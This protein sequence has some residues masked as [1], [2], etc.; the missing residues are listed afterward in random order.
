[1]TAA[2]ELEKV[3]LVADFQEFGDPAR[4]DDHG[5]FSALLARQQPEVGAAGEDKGV[6]VFG[7]RLRHF[8]EAGRAQERLAAGL[9]AFCRLGR[10]LC[11]HVRLITAGPG[12]AARLHR[13][14]DDGAVAGAAAEVAGQRVVHRLGVDPL[15]APAQRIE[16]HDEA[17]RA[18]AALGAVAVGHGRLHRVQAVAARQPLHGQHVG[19]V[20]VRQG[21]ETGIDRPE[22]PAVLVPVPGA[23]GAIGPGGQHHRAGAAIPFGAAFLGAGEARML[24]DIVQRR[25]VGRHVPDDVAP[26]V[27]MELQRHPGEP[28]RGAGA[29]S[30]AVPEVGN[31]IVRAGAPGGSAGRRF[32]EE[33]ADRRFVPMAAGLRPFGSQVWQKL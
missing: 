17:R 14:V 13:R 15:A 12:L 32:A 2:P 4:M 24:A 18:V 21:Q 30:A 7:E 22:G 31:S 9:V 28:R 26:A 8:G 11:R 33:R 29:A 5:Q 25:D 6:R 16:G 19:A 1:M 27:E 3:G 10:R 20:E 23:G